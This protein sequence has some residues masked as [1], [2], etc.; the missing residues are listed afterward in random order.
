[1]K[2]DRPLNRSKTRR[3]LT[4]GCIAAVAG[5]LFAAAQT[6]PTS[7][8]PASAGPADPKL[9]EDLVAAYRILADQGILDAMG[10]VSVRHDRNP[11]RFLMSRAVA[12]ELVT[13]DDIMEF[14][15]DSNPADAQN[16]AL[17]RERFIHG[18]IYKARAEREGDRSQ[19]FTLADPFWCNRR[20]FAAGIPYGPIRCGGS[21]GLRY[22]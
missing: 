7:Q 15:L 1:M 9:I 13:V 5:A 12:P 18:E 6:S 2:N 4:A 14:D 17:N 19:P 8:P 11:N 3:A 20:A 22:S 21:A 16:R 10:H